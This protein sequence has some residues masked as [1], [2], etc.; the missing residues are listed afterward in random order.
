MA[1][2]NTTAAVTVTA[3]PMRVPC[4]VRTAAILWAVAVAAGVFE[5]V[6]AIAGLLGERPVPVG[7]LVAGM[8]VRLVAFGVAGYLVVQ[9][10]RGRNWA[11]WALTLLLGVL[12]T[13]SLLIDPIRWLSE[14]D[15]LGDTLAAFT[16]ADWLFAASRAVHLG[17]VGAALV[18]MFRPAANRYLGATA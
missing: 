14:G 5:T 4:P 9:L 13:A 3:S 18:S 6:L 12:G 17:A 10:L 8:G 1:R 11:R 16:V 7:E 15:E 2:R